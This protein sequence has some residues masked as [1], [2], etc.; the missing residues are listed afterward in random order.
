MS[1]AR[2]NADI[3]AL[4]PRAR[5]AFALLLCER[6]LPNLQL[7]CAAT[8]QLVG[9]APNALEAL[10]ALAIGER[11]TIGEH[12]GERLDQFLDEF[13]DGDS[14]GAVASRHAVMAI[15]CALDLALEG[16]GDGAIEVSRLSRDDV[17]LFLEAQH[18]EQLVLRDQPLMQDEFAVQQALVEALNEAHSRDALLALRQELR[19]V[20]VSNLGISGD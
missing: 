10:W 4:A 11:K 6:M 19:E 7:Y 13:D 2:L 5:L 14:A 8:A 9:P 17:R 18:G 16:E 1:S 20:G 15:R 12:W 3:R